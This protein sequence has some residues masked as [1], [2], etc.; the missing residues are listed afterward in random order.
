M[1]RLAG[2]ND[3]VDED[4]DD[5]KKRSHVVS[6]RLQLKKLKNDTTTTTTVGALKTEQVSCQRSTPLG[7]HKI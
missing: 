6:E 2:G 3:T 1:L 7:G 4:V 5:K